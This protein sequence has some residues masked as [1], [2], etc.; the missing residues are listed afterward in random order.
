MVLIFVGVDFS[1]KLIDWC[2]G[3]VFIFGVIVNILWFFIVCEV[4]EDGNDC[5]GNLG[6]IG[7]L[8]KGLSIF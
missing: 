5:I 6:E 3:K 8:K 1:M 2:G 4:W 7:Y